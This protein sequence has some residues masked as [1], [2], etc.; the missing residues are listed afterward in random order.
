MV[1]SVCPLESGLVLMTGQKVET[2]EMTYVAA[3]VRHETL[4]SISFLS[5]GMLALGIQPPCSEGAQGTR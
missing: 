1:G 3:E 2:L 4:R 5:L